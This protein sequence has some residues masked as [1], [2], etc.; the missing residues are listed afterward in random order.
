MKKISIA[1]F[2]SGLLS[3]CTTAAPSDAPVLPIGSSHAKLA[4]T[5]WHWSTDQP[6]A[7]FIKFLANGH[8]RGSTGCNTISG[9][10]EETTDIKDGRHV[11]NLGNLITT[12]MACAAGMATEAAFLQKLTNAAAYKMSGDKL[13]LYNDRGDMVFGLDRQAD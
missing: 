2:L 3:A 5:A 7:P 8:I 13:K 9:V 12:E 1:I 6:N 11:F 10:Y 4:G